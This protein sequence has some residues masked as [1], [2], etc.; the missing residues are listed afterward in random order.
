MS[1]LIIFSG[2]PDFLKQMRHNPLRGKELRK[3]QRRFGRGMRRRCFR[4][5]LARQANGCQC[6][7]RLKL[8]VLQ[9]F[10]VLGNK[11]RFFMQLFNAVSVAWTKERMAWK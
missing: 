7:N 1:F 2:K 3:T 4:Q 11:N 6:I 10:I 9:L 8:A 5:E